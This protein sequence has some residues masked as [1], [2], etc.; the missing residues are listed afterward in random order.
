MVLVKPQNSIEK[1]GYRAS[2]FSLLIFLLPPPLFI[3]FACSSGHKIDPKT[4]MNNNRSIYRYLKALDSGLHSFLK[5]YVAGFGRAAKARFY[6][7]LLLILS[8]F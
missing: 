7:P 1:S 4:N 5:I 3:R 8:I 6:L 2:C